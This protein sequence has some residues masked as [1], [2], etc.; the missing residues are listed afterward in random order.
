MKSRDAGSKGV[1]LSRSGDRHPLARATNTKCVSKRMSPGR[2]ASTFRKTPCQHTEAG[3][4]AD[5][6]IAGLMHA[7]HPQTGSAGKN[8]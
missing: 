6:G 5:R 7:A 8:T 2:A 3:P 1:V 4:D